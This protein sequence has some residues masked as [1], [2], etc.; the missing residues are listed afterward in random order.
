[1]TMRATQSVRLKKHSVFVLTSSIDE[2][3]VRFFL[4]NR[5]IKFEGTETPRN[6]LLKIPRHFLLRKLVAQLSTINTFCVTQHV[7]FTTKN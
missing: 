7:I 3:C 6:H 4:A 2:E 1:M 5:L